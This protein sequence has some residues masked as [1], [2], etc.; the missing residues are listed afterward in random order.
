ME[1][2]KRYAIYYAPRPGGFARAAASWLG[3]DAEAGSAVA[4]PALILPRALSEITAE[5]RKYGFHATLKP[6]FRL[7]EGYEIA[8]LRQAVTSLARSLA[9]LRLEG[10]SLAPLGGFLALQPMGDTSDL[11]D[12]AAEVVRSLDPYRASLTEAETARRRPESL[13]PRQRELLAVYGYPYVMEEFRFHLT[14]T[15]RLGAELA[16]VQRAAET[17][18]AGLIPQPF[19]LEDLCLFGE[20][21]AGRFH[22]LHRYPLSA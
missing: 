15:D 7:A 4:Q 20:D 19:D 6:P 22:L 13:T 9:P 1:A 16:E 17:H 5:P 21:R 12:L 10:L 14:L 11:A 3:W 8:D 2:I 18:F